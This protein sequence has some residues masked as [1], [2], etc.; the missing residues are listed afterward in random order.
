MGVVLVGHALGVRR[1]LGR[2]ALAA[3]HPGL[4]TP[5][6]ALG[7]PTIGPAILALVTPFALFVF[8][9]YPAPTGGAPLVGVNVRSRLMIG[10]ALIG[11][12][13]GTLAG[14]FF[15]GNR[16]GD[17]GH[18]MPRLDDAVGIGVAIIT[19]ALGIRAAFRAPR[20]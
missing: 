16:S 19:L 14:L 8:G 3:A 1:F 12:T 18:R 15:F 20:P 17:L 5:T 9:P 6:R 11:G 4:G 13:L 7:W 10:W 2:A